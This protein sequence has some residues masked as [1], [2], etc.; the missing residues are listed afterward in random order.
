MPNNI[1]E[2]ESRSACTF[3]LSLCVAVAASIN[4]AFPD[5]GPGSPKSSCSN[6]SARPSQN[7]ETSR[8]QLEQE[9]SD[10]GHALVH[11]R[12]FQFGQFRFR[13]LV[14]HNDAE[15]ASRQPKA[16]NNLLS[17]ADHHV[18]HAYIAA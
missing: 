13:S 4:P 12:P 2:N 15:A 18:L 6:L 3:V 7:N 8:E 9:D 14:G 5:R 16:S 17:C 11:N 1:T 10:A